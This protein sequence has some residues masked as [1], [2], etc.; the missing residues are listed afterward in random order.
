MHKMNEQANGFT[1]FSHNNNK[2]KHTS[3]PKIIETPNGFQPFHDNK[4]VLKTVE[5]RSAC[6]NY[7]GIAVIKVNIRRVNARV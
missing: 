3:I 5:T 7:F 4:L 6:L 1:C 2:S